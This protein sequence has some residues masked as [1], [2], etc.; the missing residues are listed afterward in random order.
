MLGVC[1][2]KFPSLW[3]LIV[4]V[5]IMAVLMEFCGRHKGMR[6]DS[7]AVDP[8]VYQSEER[9]QTQRPWDERQKKEAFVGVWYG[10]QGVVDAMSTGLHELA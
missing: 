7:T 1:G 8:R 5:L 9:R 2:C 3:L 6:R 10:R 4:F